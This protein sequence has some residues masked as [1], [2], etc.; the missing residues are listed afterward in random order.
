MTAITN[1]ELASHHYNLYQQKTKSFHEN[2]LFSFCN[3]N[4]QYITLTGFNS[5]TSRHRFFCK[6]C[7]VVYTSNQDE[8]AAHI[9]R[10][11]NNVIIK[12]FQKPESNTNKTQQITHQ[13]HHINIPKINNQSKPTYKNENQQTI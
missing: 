8:I 11:A 4:S 10:H 2:G 13:Q 9:Q 5:N 7:D 12:I 3:N 1:E 6:L